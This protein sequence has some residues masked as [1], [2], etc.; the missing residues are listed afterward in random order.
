MKNKKEL[1]EAIHLDNQLTLE[2]MPDLDLYM[3]QVI[4]LF[5]NKYASSKRNEKEKV[6]TKTM[7]NN[8][9][10]GKLFF[11]IKDKKYSKEHMILISMIYQMKST[12]SISDVKQTLNQL[13]SGIT[14]GNIDLKQLYQT[15]LDLMQ[16]NTAM[17]TRDIEEQIE[18]V[19]SEVEQLENEDEEYLEQLLLVATFSSMSNYYR[20]AAEMMVDKIGEKGEDKYEA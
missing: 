8:Y 18:A 9:A 15:Y 14:E 16:N 19:R 12:L 5:E 11:P 10:K 1:M 7:V 6:L 17:F 2:D 3:D 20:R 13:N 4:Q